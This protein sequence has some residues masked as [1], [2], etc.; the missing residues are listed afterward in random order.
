[1]IKHCTTCKKTTY[2]KPCRSGVNNFCSRQCY[3]ASRKGRPVGWIN[4]SN[5][6]SIKESISKAKMGDKN[7][8]YNR[9]A[10]KHH[11]WQGG[12]SATIWK[13][14]EYQR[15]RK[16]V[17]SRDNFTCQHCGDNS[18]GNLEADH[19]KPRCLFP[20]LT[21]DIDNGRTLC[22]DCH[23]QTRTWG[24]KVKSLTRADFSL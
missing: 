10:E 2:I 19:I 17:M 15:W 5:A 6:E 23:K 24:Y 3:F 20:E 22:Q 12:K 16:A 13:S 1:M 4:G 7:W 11:L 18:G 21:F 14:V 9:V 8:M